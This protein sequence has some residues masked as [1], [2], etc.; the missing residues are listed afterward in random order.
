MLPSKLTIREIQSLE[1]TCQIPL[2]AE[3]SIQYFLWGPSSTR[4]LLCCDHV[5]RVYSPTSAK[6]AATVT[7][8]TSST[9]KITYLSFGATDNE[10]YVFAD[11]GLKLV[12]YDLARGNAVELL[13]PKL[14][15]AA[16]APKGY[17][18]RPK[19]QQ[20]TLLTRHAGKDV[21]S[22]HT[23][24]SQDIFRSWTAESVD[25][26]AISWSPDGKWLSVWESAAQGHKVLFYTADGHLY[27]TWR[28][29]TSTSEEEKHAD[30]GAGVKIFE[31]SSN[32]QYVAIGD[33]SLG[34]TIIAMPSCA[35]VLRLH[36]TTPIK[37][38]FALQIWQ[39]QVSAS[40]E[41][42]YVLAQQVTAPPTLTTSPATDQGLA[43]RGTVTLAFD[44]S[45]TLLATRSESMPT[46][47]WIWDLATGL[48]RAV[49]IQHG[50]VAKVTWHPHINELLMIR[51]E[52]D[53]NK[54]LVYIWE[55]SWEEPRIV[56][57]G[58]Q[59]A[60][61]QI[62][63][64]SIARWLD[65]EHTVPA[66]FFTDTQDCILAALTESE[67]DLVPWQGAVALGTDLYGSRAESTLEFVEP[68]QEDVGGVEESMLD[69]GETWNG[70]FDD[71]VDDIDDTFHFKV[72]G[73]RIRQNAR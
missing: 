15:T 73:S 32:S 13:S 51:C 37:P 45:G 38:T 66:I 61:N 58:T 56:D 57:F 54:G 65:S 21:I 55:P 4:F 36:H 48:L 6:L 72:E 62:I 11:F 71:T 43:N 63:G 50:P 12:V 17:S 31:W 29:P 44:A 47:V 52:G 23:R 46:T 59:I 9:T 64:R 70:D 2:Q 68:P 49:L 20:L 69:E 8:P 24:L 22:I 34:V 3:K 26:Q 27:K 35:E 39:E 19:T 14:Y 25:A 16:L 18:H 41:R 42:K 33:F 1:I 5:I 28:G 40:R 10:I 60:G 67:D 53:N 30:V 7:N